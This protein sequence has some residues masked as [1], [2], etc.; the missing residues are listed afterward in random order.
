MIPLDTLIKV[1]RVHRAGSARTLQCLQR[2]QDHRQSGTRLHLGRCDQGD[3]GSGGADTA[4]RGGFQIAWTGSA[5]QELE[6]GGAG[7]QAMIFGIIMVFLILAAQY[8]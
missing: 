3:A 5:Y 6:T 4:A 2:C 7:T 1:T 8:E